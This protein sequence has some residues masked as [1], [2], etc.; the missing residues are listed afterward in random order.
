MDA[1]SGTET[2]TIPIKNHWQHRATGGNLSPFN[3][4]P[5]ARSASTTEATSGCTLLTLFSFY[6]DERIKGF[7]NFLLFCS[8][9]NFA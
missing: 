1:I 8:T 5:S 4:P 3:Q 2:E 9:T 6:A 7:L